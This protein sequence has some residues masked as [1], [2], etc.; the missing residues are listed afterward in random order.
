MICCRD[1]SGTSSGMDMFLR[2]TFIFY[3]YDFL[4]AIDRQLGV[5]HPA[6]PRLY[7]Q[8]FLFY[9]ENCISIRIVVQ[10]RPLLAHPPP[11]TIRIEES[12]SSQNYRTTYENKPR[13]IFF[14]DV[15]IA[16]TCANEETFSAR[17]NSVVVHGYNSGHL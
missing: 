13:L 12:K 10:S 17:K 8:S 16:S 5:R 6:S 14:R 1:R 15:C 9:K 4:P 3:L 11:W 7:T 2:H